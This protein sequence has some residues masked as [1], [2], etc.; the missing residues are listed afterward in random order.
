MKITIFDSKITKMFAPFFLA[1]AMLGAVAAVSDANIAEAKEKIITITPQK[2][3]DGARANFE[4]EK[5]Q[6]NLRETSKKSPLRKI[7]DNLVVYNSDRLNYNDGK[8]ERWLEPIGIADNTYPHEGSSC[9]GYTYVKQWYEDQLENYFHEYNIVQY[10][11]TAA[12]L[13]HEYGHFVNKDSLSWVKGQPQS[14]QR[15]DEFGADQMGMELLDKV[16]EYSMG[17]MVARATGFQGIYPTAW[18]DLKILEDWSY[19]RVKFVQIDG[20]NCL[21]VDGVPFTV[22]QSHNLGASW[23]ASGDDRTMYLMGQIASCIHHGMWKKRNIFWGPESNYFLNGRSDC[24]TLFVYDPNSDV[25][26]KFLATFNITEADIKE[27]TN[28]EMTLMNCEKKWQVDDF[29]FIRNWPKD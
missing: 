14:A 29:N 16:P 11:N 15:D 26:I 13:A 19:D 20:V 4:K 23:D 24:T 2:E 18:D 28:A 22:R 17:S 8:H 21:S 27:L 12:L 9:A 1:V 6:Y 10:S 3:R 7:Q 5:A 25:Q